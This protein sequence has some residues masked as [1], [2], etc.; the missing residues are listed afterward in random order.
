V[1][2]TLCSC[3]TQPEGEDFHW[4]GS[5]VTTHFVRCLIDDYE[6]RGIVFGIRSFINIFV[7]RVP[8]GEGK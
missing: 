3:S 2:L 8:K 6:W 4:D 7:L 1:V 5:L